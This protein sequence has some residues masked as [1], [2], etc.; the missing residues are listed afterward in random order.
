[1]ARIGKKVVSTEEAIA[2]LSAHGADVTYEPHFLT[3]E[4]AS[5]SLVALQQEIEFP[6]REQTLVFVHGMWRQQPRSVTAH[7]DE[8]MRYRYSHTCVHARPW[9]DAPALLALQQLL[10]RRTGFRASLALVNRYDDGSDSIAPHSDDERDLGPAPTIVSLSLGA[11]RLFRFRRR[12]AAISRLPGVS[13]PLG[14]GSLLT[15]RHPANRLWTHEIPKAGGTHPERI[16]LRV[17]I[18]WRQVVA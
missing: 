12:D 18:T 8:G 6:P 11:E 15:M 1:M 9:A 13:L 2:F 16:G 5:A 10:L 4:A 14:H 17:N 7:G 3:P